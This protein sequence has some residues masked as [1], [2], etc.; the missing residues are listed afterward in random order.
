MSHRTLAILMVGLLAVMSC[1][2]PL[3]VSDCPDQV[4]I[5][6]GAGTTPEI[7]WT[8]RCHLVGLLITS[9]YT[10]G[11]VWSIGGPQRGVCG[12]DGQ[13]CYWRNTLYP[14]IRYGVVPQDA[15]QDFP[16]DQKP[17]ALRVGWPYELRLRRG[18]RAL[19]REVWLAVETFVV[20]AT[21]GTSP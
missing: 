3:A 5:S 20:T 16:P 8:P 7:D 10:G 9:T 6:V 19:P 14:P 4:Q 15:V 21:P 17:Q 11:T 18:G 12:D 1:E 2:D 13:Q